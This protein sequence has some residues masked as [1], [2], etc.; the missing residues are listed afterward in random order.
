MDNFELKIVSEG[1]SS[2]EKALGI[3]F[4]KHNSATHYVITPK[5]ICLFWMKPS[6]HKE[7][8]PLPFKLHT[9]NVTDFVWSWLKEADY[10]DEPDHDGSNGKGWLVSTDPGW[11]HVEGSFYGICK[12][13]PEWAMYGK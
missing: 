3:A 5:K 8:I 12:I 2:L 4:A 13:E 10:G 6:D 1:K 7:A 11:G 9:D